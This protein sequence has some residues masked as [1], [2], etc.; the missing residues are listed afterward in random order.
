MDL[1]W[2]AVRLF[3]ALWCALRQILK[4]SAS[5]AAISFSTPF[6]AND[7]A[8]PCARLV[9]SRSAMRGFASLSGSFLLSRIQGQ[10]QQARRVNHPLLAST[11]IKCDL[12]RK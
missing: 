12:C 6:Y 3:A 1:A 7:V 5:R 2:R 9:F 11:H 8:R 10:E 4:E